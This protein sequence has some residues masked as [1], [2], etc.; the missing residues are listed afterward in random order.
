MTKWELTVPLLDEGSREDPHEP[1]QT[2]QLHLEF[3]QHVV[4]GAVELS[5]A[6][7]QFV[8]HH[9]VHQHRL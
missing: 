6:P 1:G 8:V 2:H 5:S 3:L 9:L 7:V 4:D